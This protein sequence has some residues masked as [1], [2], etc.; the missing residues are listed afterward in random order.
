M[1]KTLQEAWRSL[2][3]P[4]P[5]KAVWGPPRIY[6]YGEHVINPTREMD[7]KTNGDLSYFPFRK[8]A[9]RRSVE[10]TRPTQFVDSHMA[11]F[12]E[13][14]FPKAQRIL[15]FYRAAEHLSDHAKLYHAGDS[16]KAEELFATRRHQLRHEGGK[17]MLKTLLNLYVQDPALSR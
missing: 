8:T 10:R 11:V 6:Q 3:S 1:G 7:R 16:A 2:G 13:V 9:Y 15:D 4:T 12:F 14:N 17:A 5:D